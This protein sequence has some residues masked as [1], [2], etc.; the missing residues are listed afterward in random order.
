MF[1]SLSDTQHLLHSTTLNSLLLTMAETHYTNWSPEEIQQAVYRHTTC[2][3]VVV[4]LWPTEF[5][6]SRAIIP[7]AIREELVSGIGKQP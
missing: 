1:K 2:I 3:T 5:A 4:K 7:A 6:E